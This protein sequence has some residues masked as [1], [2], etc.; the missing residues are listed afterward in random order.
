MQQVLWD[1]A[2]YSA[3]Q[4]PSEALH[5]VAGDKAAEAGIA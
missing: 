4:W 3:G 5:Q 1:C 2:C